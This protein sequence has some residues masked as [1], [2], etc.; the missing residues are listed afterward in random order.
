MATFRKVQFEMKRTGYGQYLIVANYKGQRVTARITDSEVWDNLNSDIKKESNAAHR[1]CYY[2]IV[3][4][5][6]Y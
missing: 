6:S 3:E 1:A 5:Y 2:K 4:A